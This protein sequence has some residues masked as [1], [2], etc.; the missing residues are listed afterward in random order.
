MKCTID[1][2]LFT[3]IVNSIKDLN[4]HV[5][6]DFTSDGLQFQVM[7]TGHVS[8]SHLVLTS[9][10]LKDYTCERNLTLGI[11]LQS[12][13]LVLRGSTNSLSMQSDGEKLKFHVEKNSG[14][15]NY[16]LNLIDIE[17]DKL[18]VPDIAYK[19]KAHMS[20]SVFANVV[21][22]ISDISNVCRISI[23]DQVHM[24]A[25]GD[26]G[27]VEWTSSDCQTCVKEETS[28][29]LFSI[30][31]LVHFA[32]ARSVSKEVTL[33]MSE[34]LPIRI[35]Y[36]IGSGFLCFYLAPKLEDEE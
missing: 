5:N 20:S 2:K 22:D 11:N 8:L 24:S 31:Y 13:S 6:F 27:H 26:I 28:P 7:D 12:L 35:T 33:E 17:T 18:K 15:A 30:A 19:T 4:S 14:S 29:L 21:K 10:V 25:T 16:T 1:A 3:N 36:S 32:N 9:D 23:G 34:D